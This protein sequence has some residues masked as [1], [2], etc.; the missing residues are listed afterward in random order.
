M[1]A[2]F[3]VNPKR[4]PV[5]ATVKETNPIPSKTGMRRNDVLKV[6]VQEMQENK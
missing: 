1:D 3:G 4:S 2:V 6:A 5:P